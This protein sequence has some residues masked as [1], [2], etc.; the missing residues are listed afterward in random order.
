[1]SGTMTTRELGKVAGVHGDT[2]RRAARKLFPHKLIS[3]GKRAHW[4]KEESEAI[5][6]EVR[7]RNLVSSPSQNAE[8]PSQTAKVSGSG[9][10][11]ED[12][13]RIAF[14]V[15]R[16]M[17]RR[18]AVQDA[19]ID[20]LEERLEE[21]APLLPPPLDERAELNRIVKRFAQKNHLGYSNVWRSLYTEYG[22]RCHL[23]IPKRAEN[24]DMKPID[25]AAQ[26][27]LLRQ[28][29]AVAREVLR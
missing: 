20:R 21:Q 8:V 1:M 26:E 9:L 12:F 15:D 29:V 11:D 10:S 16:V 22:Y 24:R 18:L 23:D 19:R 13:E 17:E 28:L 5:I 3:N 4:S 27:G 6:R 25:Y 2:I 7:K 14:I